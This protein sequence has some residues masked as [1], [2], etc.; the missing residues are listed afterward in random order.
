MGLISIEQIAV[1]LHQHLRKSNE[2]HLKR[3]VH[4]DDIPIDDLIVLARYVSIRF[5]LAMFGGKDIQIRLKVSKHIKEV[6]RKKHLAFDGDEEEEKFVE[7]EPTGIGGWRYANRLQEKVFRTLEDV[8]NQG[9][10]GS[11]QQVVNA[12]KALISE[13]SKMKASSMELMEAY[14]KQLIILAEF[15]VEKFLPSLGKQLR[16]E[17]RTDIDKIMISAEKRKNQDDIL[18][19][20]KNETETMLRRW[21]IKRYELLLAELFADDKEVS[22]AFNFTADM[23]DTFLKEKHVSLVD[24][25]A[26]II[27]K[28]QQKGL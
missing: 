26:I 6:E 10:T 22:Q 17:L 27:T 11:G 18:K 2:K 3:G 12:S 19:F 5:I 16:A 25:S 13:V 9:L 20:V 4:T 24:E 7:K 21:G 15:Y 28:S 1:D 23:I 14:E 8:I